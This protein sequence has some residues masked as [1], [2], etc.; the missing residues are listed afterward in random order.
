MYKNIRT[1]LML[2]GGIY[3]LFLLAGCA[4][5]PTVNNMAYVPS[6]AMKASVSHKLVNSIEVQEVTGGKKTNAL[7]IPQVD[8]ESLKNSLI[9]SL[10][11]SGFY[12]EM[13]KDAKYELNANIV[14]L[15]VP[16]T[17]I[18]M[19]VTC[20]IHYQLL[21]LSANNAVIY[22]KTISSSYAPDLDLS[23]SNLERQEMGVAG[24]VKANIEQLI[25]DLH[26]I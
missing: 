15:D 21:Q 14:K 11:Q 10:Q 23:M 19:K 6:T 17:D 13:L 4:K 20:V 3:F 25:A 5:N 7:W 22:D 12:S 8:N 16:L 1:T 26:S 2:V 18:E 24:A 9:Q